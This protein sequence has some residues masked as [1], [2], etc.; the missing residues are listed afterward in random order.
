MTGARLI[1]NADDFGMS[2]GISDGIYLAHRYGF[3]TSTSMMVNMPASEYAIGRLA[4]CPQLGV[5]IH[6]NVCQGKPLMPPHAVRSLINAAGNFHGPDLMARKL[7]R[8]QVSSIELEAEFRAQIQWLKRYVGEVTHADSHQHMHL[9]PG[10]LRPFAH[11]VRAEQIPCV[12]AS[13]CTAWPKASA[14]GGPHAGSAPRR[15]AVQ[16]YRRAVHSTI[17]RD[18][19]SPSSRIAF[20]GADRKKPGSL[21]RCWESTFDN[22]AAGTYE[23][24][25]HPGLLQPGFSHADRI[26]QQREDEL[27]W[28]TSPEMRE[29]IDRNSIELITYRQLCNRESRA[30][31]MS[32]N[33]VERQAG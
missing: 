25:C 21:D 1:V 23:L 28:L 31:S 15:V 16:L 17:F 12:R 29:A 26:A 4:R 14:L 33:A 24:S 13:R 20:R 10:A 7:S 19:R 2:I 30:V 8:F 3:L 11:A 5:G 27:R 6:L 18:F 32:R 9:F 22:L